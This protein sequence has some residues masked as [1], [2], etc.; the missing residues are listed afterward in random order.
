MADEGKTVIFISHKLHEVKAVADRVTVLRGRR[1]VATVDAASATAR[2]LA[3]LMVGREIEVVRPLEHA[4][5]WRTS[6]CST[7]TG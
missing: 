6:R 5:H 2:S 7:W 1:T 3:S 4:R